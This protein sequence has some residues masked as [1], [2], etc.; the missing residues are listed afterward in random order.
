[1]LLHLYSSSSSSSS[2]MLVEV[3]DIVV[4]EDIIRVIDKPITSFQFN[5][6]HGFAVIVRC[7]GPNLMRVEI[8]EKKEDLP[9][10]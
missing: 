2:S 6:H 1:M 4:N 5:L 3:V 8:L 9:Y 10:R 7:P